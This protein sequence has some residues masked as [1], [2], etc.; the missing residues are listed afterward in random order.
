MFI[1]VYVVLAILLIH[2][3]AFAGTPQELSFDESIRKLAFL[4]GDNMSRKHGGGIYE[5][6]LELRESAVTAIEKVPLIDNEN[7]S[8]IVSS[9]GSDGITIRLQYDETVEKKP[10]L[11]FKN[12]LVFTRLTHFDLG[13]D[14][15]VADREFDKLIFD[16]PH[17]WAELQFNSEKGSLAARAR[18]AHIENDLLKSSY[19]Q[20]TA[21][22]LEQITK[23]SGRIQRLLPSLIQDSTK[24]TQESDLL[25]LKSER[26]QK[27][28]TDTWRSET[29][30]LDQWESQADK[31]ND[32]IL[33]N[34]RQAVAQM[35]SDF[36][37]W[38]S[39]SP[40]ESS[41]WNLWLEAIRHPDLTKSTVAF[42]GVDYATD[43]IQRVNMPDGE[44]RVAF[45]STVLT[46][47]QGS[48]T[49]RLR[50]LSVNRLQNGDIAIEK[51]KSG[52]AVVGISDQ[53]TNH[54]HEPRSSSF[55]SFTYDP[56]VA[57]KFV[58]RKKILDDKG[59]MKHIPN[60]GTLAV[61]IDSRRLFPNIMS[62]Y[63]GEIE[64][65][66]P[67]VIFPDEVVAYKEGPFT[68]QTNNDT[69]DA[70]LETVAEKTNTKVTIWTDRAAK[71]SVFKFYF[72][73]DGYG[74][75]EKFLPNNPIS[76]P[77]CS[78]IFR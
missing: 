40:S 66:A 14:I 53:M 12:L 60:G 25:A 5:N 9:Y 31:L 75:M 55:L 17:T 78:R 4:I 51:Y 68:G 11:L 61:R 47:N 64:L 30:T 1:R 56:W 7:H 29:K 35:I 49:R 32:L 13:A 18:L 52:A 77:L 76:A 42:R 2:N 57:T 23:T 41:A 33:K 50:S 67:L 48:Y 16:S 10:E 46:K 6:Q 19:A 71:K 3:F 15:R 37:P 70:F 27:K 43:K 74:F 26:L 62:E 34:D 36:L 28:S 73:R 20:P 63:P 69:M 21:E 44:S 22:F 45:M 72:K 39:M 59:K 8:R 24:Q 38:A 58:G 54:A 65:L